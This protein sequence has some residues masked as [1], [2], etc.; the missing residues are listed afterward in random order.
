MS[1]EDEMEGDLNEEDFYP[2]GIK[3]VQN[4]SNIDEE[5]EEE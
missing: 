4:L 3:E 1:V 2:S 5:N